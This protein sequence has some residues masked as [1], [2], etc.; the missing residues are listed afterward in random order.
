MSD[1]LISGERA[2]TLE[3]MIL[4]IHTIMMVMM[5]QLTWHNNTDNTRAAHLIVL[6]NEGQ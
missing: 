6:A 5:V 2:E 1:K 4:L 3:T